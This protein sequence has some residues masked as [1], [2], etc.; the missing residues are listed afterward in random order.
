MKLSEIWDPS[1]YRAGDESDPRSPYYDGRNEPHEEEAQSTIE[2]EYEVI[3]ENN[4][5]HGIGELTLEID[6]VW[7]S[8]PKSGRQH[9]DDDPYTSEY[10]LKA[11]KAVK[12][13]LSGKTYTVA[14]AEHEFG[15]DVFDE[16]AIWEEALRYIKD[17][18]LF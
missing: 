11:V 13:V 1:Q 4:K 2:V 10:K 7:V 3:D 17:N 14:Q 16:A 12:L 18:D 9:P 15:K 6:G 8:T 5:S